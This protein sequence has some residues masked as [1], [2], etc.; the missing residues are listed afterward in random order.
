MK[1]CILEKRKKDISV[2]MY[3]WK[4]VSMGTVRTARPYVICI[5]VNKSNLVNGL[6]LVFF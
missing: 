1:Y 4:F 3:V 2:T 5:I 6:V